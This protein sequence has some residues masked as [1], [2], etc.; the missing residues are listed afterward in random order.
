MRKLL[1]FIAFLV[2]A[3]PFLLIV[4]RYTGW[5]LISR[6]EYYYLVVFFL[7]GFWVWNMKTKKNTDTN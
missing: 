2:I 1:I 3:I 5:E 7:L 6:K 4:Q